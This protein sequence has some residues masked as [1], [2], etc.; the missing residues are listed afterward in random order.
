MLLRLFIFC[1]GITI[2][3]VGPSRVIVLYCCGISTHVRISKGNYKKLT[4]IGKKKESY[5][6]IIGRLIKFYQER[7]KEND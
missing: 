2:L 1:S 5:D 3:I 6:E 7:H 4:E